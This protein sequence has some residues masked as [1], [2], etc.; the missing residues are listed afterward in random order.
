M[1]RKKRY[2]AGGAAPAEEDT[3]LWKELL[4]AGIGGIGG[5]F[6]GI[7]PGMGPAWLERLRRKHPA[8]VSPAPPGPPPAPGAVYSSGGMVGRARGAG[9]ATRG[10][11]Y[12]HC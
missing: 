1:P 4:A 11:K 6:G 3:P 10:N 12:K 9:K 8:A 7:L 2:Q 5:G